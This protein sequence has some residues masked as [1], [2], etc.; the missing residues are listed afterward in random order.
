MLDALGG[1]ADPIHILDLAVAQR[2]LPALM[3]SAPVNAL[4]Q[5]PALLDGLPAARGLLRLP[6]PIQL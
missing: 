4:R 6:L 5:L 2:I 3:A 1:D